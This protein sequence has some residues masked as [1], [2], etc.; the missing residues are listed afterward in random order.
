MRKNQYTGIVGGRVLRKNSH[1]RGT[2]C[3]SSPFAAASCPQ[4]RVLVRSSALG[5]L[6]RPATIFL[7]RD[8]LLNEE[9]ILLKN[10]FYNLLPIRDISTTLTIYSIC[11]QQHILTYSSWCKF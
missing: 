2:C 8:D 10:K 4:P 11:D 5:S 9:Q 1:H 3:T 6:A 7:T